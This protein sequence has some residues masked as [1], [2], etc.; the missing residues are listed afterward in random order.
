MQ[1]YTLHEM[2]GMLRLELWQG[3][4]IDKL[5][6]VGPVTSRQQKATD[7]G[8]NG[9]YISANAM[10]ES[11]ELSDSGTG[12]SL[13][14]SLYNPYTA[15]YDI[16]SLET[17]AGKRDWLVSKIGVIASDKRDDYVWSHNINKKNIFNIERKYVAEYT[18]VRSGSIGGPRKSRIFRR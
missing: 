9:I 13:S 7:C 15:A 5:G 1:I 6:Y 12:C 17:S 14:I 2:I 11:C 10:I 16:Y 8:W 4:M 18:N 3:G